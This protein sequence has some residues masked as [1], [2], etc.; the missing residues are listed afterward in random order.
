MERRG[1]RQARGVRK[2]N[3]ALARVTGFRLTRVGAQPTGPQPLAKQG[4]P[5]RPGSGHGPGPVRAKGQA[6]G[7]GERR[8]PAQQTARRHDRKGG[9]KRTRTK[10]TPAQHYDDAANALISRVRPR[11]M[12]S[13]EKLYPLILAVRHVV[14]AGIEGD[15]V[16]CG[17]WRGGSMQAMAWTLLAEGAKDRDLHLFDTFEGMPPPGEH[18]RRTKDS[19]AADHLLEQHDLS[20]PVWA[21]AGLEDVRQGMAETGYPEERIHFVPGMVEDTIPN[22]APD[23]IA[24]LRLDTDWYASTRHELEHLYPRLVPGGVLLLD[25]YGYWDGARR[26][27]EEFLATIDDKLLLLPMAEGRIAIKPR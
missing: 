7:R 20:H 14:A 15:F 10:I 1:G 6:K 26:A 17:V 27:T 22:Q 2:L 21:Y 9:A 12:T 23:R 3:D 13:P 25:D 11:T 19:M 8:G 4:Q 16:E 24:V 18:D 5:K